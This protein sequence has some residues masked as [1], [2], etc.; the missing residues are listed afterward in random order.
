MYGTAGTKEGIDL[1]LKH[2]ATACF[3]HREDGYM[4]RVVVCLIII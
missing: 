3:N 1:V 4:D 2:G